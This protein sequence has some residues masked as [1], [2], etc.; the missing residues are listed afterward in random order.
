MAGVCSQ[1]H[2]QV[3]GPGGSRSKWVLLMI[4]VSLPSDGD[5]LWRQKRGPEGGGV[6]RGGA[7][8]MACDSCCFC[9]AGPFTPIYQGPGASAC[10]GWEALCT[11]TGLGS[12]EMC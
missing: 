1:R 5:Q 2:K 3:S 12:G 9:L 10:R 8:L 6:S 11:G 4:W 7:P